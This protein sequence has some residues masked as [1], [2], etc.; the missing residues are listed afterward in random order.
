[1]IR[2]EHIFAKGEDPQYSQP[3]ALDLKGLFHRLDLVSMRETTLS[4]NQWLDQAKRLN[5]TAHSRDFNGI[6]SSN[7]DFHSELNEN[8]QRRMSN[9]EII[10]NP[11]EIRTFIVDFSKTK[12]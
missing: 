7:Q 4:A 6:T 8:K 10:L 3:V 5:F 11:M 2:F 1:M 12:T 9:F